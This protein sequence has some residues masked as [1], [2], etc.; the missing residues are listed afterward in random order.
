MWSTE[1][2]TVIHD[3]A[4]YRRGDKMRDLLKESILADNLQVCWSSTLENC[5]ECSKCIRTM[6]A[7]NLLGGEIKSLPALREI[8]NLKTLKATDES[9]ATFLEDAMILA[10]N[11]GNIEIYKILKH[12][13]RRYQIGLIL[14]LL[15]RYLLGNFLR[16]LYR[17]IKKPDWLNYRVTLRESN[18]RDR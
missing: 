11:S 3:G 16:C 1:S 6:V 8:K 10:K 5:G 12:Y 9:G 2:T 17:K 18:G 13:Y 7:V 14:P 4:G 15:D